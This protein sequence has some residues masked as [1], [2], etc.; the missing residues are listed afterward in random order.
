MLV[1]TTCEGVVL[2]HIHSSHSSCCESNV[3]AQ[4]CVSPIHTFFVYRSGS[5]NGEQT[6]RLMLGNCSEPAQAEL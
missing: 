6:M 5:A 1:N 3:L 2:G 4:K